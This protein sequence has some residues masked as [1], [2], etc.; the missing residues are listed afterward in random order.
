MQFAF[1]TA[2]R[3]LFGEGKLAEAAPA[4]RAMGRRALVITGASQRHTIAVDAVPFAVAGEPSL[5]RVREGAALARESGCDVVIAIGGGSA[6]DAGKAIAAMLTNPGD[7]L[8][9]LE[10]IGR[11]HPLATRRPLH[12][13]PHHRRYRAR[14]SPATPCWHRP[15][16]ASRPACAAPTCCRAWPSSI[17]N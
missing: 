11:G 8:D 13:H 10:V 3:I 9:Y 5:A 7:P 14:K 17:P 2:T 6:I 15:N 12:R 1:A 4:A 16:I